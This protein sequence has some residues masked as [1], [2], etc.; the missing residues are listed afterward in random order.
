MLSHDDM[1]ELAALATDRVRRAALALAL[2]RDA[3]DT[4]G[5]LHALLMLWKKP[6]FAQQRQ[7]TYRG[8]LDILCIGDARYPSLLSATPDPPP[9]LFYRGDH[10]LL[11]RQ[12][13]AIVGSRKALPSSLTLAN[14]I[15]SDL[16]RLGIVV[17][18]GLARGVDGAAHTGS[19][20]AT[21]Q[22]SVDPAATGGT[23]AVLGAG[24]DRIYP[25]EHAGL[26]ARVAERGLL[27]TEY[28]PGV[29]PYASH[30]PQRNRIISGLARAVVVIEAG[31]QSG[32]LG[33]AREALDQGREVLVVPGPVQGGR[34]AGSHRLLRDGAALVE[35]ASDVL[36]AIGIAAIDSVATAATNP[37]IGAALSLSSDAARVL[38]CCAIEGTGSGVEAISANVGL[39]IAAVRELL[40]ELEIDGFVAHSRHG[41]IRCR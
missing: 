9:V 17:V 10:E 32:S 20:D 24:L 29:R 35:T 6:G 26:F 21:D 13:V 4:S 39:S 7:R 19:L 8:S 30:F 3:H 25:P 33:T 38:E 12:C 36:E 14:E 23:I 41:Y 37:K 2:Q 31:A 34:F 15:A 27:L 16:S 5:A 40:A 28:G 22:R 18:S 1:F 11:A